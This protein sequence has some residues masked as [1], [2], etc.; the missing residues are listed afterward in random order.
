[1]NKVA[2]LIL[3]LTG[4]MAIVISQSVSLLA[5][6]FAPHP[7]LKLAQRP[8]PS[9]GNS[10]PRGDTT[11]GTTRPESACKPTSRPLEAI[12]ANQGQ[13][14][15]T[16]PHPTF[17]FYIPY[18]PEE[19][20]SITFSLN[21]TEGET[22]YEIVETIYRTNVKLTETSGIIKITI[23]AQPEYA[24]ES[25]EL[26]KWYLTVDCK[27]EQFDEIDPG[28]PDLFVK[29]WVRR[30]PIDSEEGIFWQDEVVRL[31]ELYFS[32]PENS[33]YKENWEQ[34]LQ[35]FNMEVSIEVPL[36]D[37]SLVPPED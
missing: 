10:T 36:V 6:P 22:I 9:N 8:E 30:L 13:D 29:G 15:T 35:D 11:P 18:N 21:K 2:Q 23:P 34:F 5:A 19:I 14:W 20:N 16:S 31:A 1:M 32:E 25:G 28:I 17:L 24:L 12:V 37:F 27:S 7:L 3:P 33:E 4:A 26:Y